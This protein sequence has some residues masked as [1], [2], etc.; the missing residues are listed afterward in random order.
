MEERKGVYMVLVRKPEGQRPIGGPRHRWE[1]N[2]KMDLQEVGCRAVDGIE[3]S[4]D[5]DRWWALV[6]AVMNHR[7]P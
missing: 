5:R 1:Y 6:N 3:M 2:I 4:W 7:V